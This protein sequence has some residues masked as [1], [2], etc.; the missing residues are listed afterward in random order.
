MSIVPHL[1]ERYRELNTKYKNAS[2]YK[3]VIINTVLSKFK[4]TFFA[5]ITTIVGFGSS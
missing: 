3:L 2:Q 5:I 1:I 4:P